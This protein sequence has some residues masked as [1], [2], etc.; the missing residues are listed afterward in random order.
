MAVRGMGPKESM[1]NEDDVKN[2]EDALDITLLMMRHRG[3]RITTSPKIRKKRSHLQ[4]N[5]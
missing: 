5:T 3:L 4:Q 1:P 2:D